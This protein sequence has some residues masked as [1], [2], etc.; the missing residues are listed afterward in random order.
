MIGAAILGIVAGYLGRLL[1]P[2][3]DKMGFISTT[4][5]GLAGA[6]V[7][8]ALFNYVLG[9]GEADA[10]DFGSLLGAVVGVVILLGLMRLYRQHES[11]H[12]F[13]LHRRDHGLHT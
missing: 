12:S 7:G 3:K 11:G 6:A 9:I 8:W 4:L 13:G 10:F 2:G 5:L 1:M